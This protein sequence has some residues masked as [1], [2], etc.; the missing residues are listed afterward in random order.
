ME[1]KEGVDGHIP[2]EGQINGERSFLESIK[3][4]IRSIVHRD[5]PKGLKAHQEGLE[6]RL[7]AMDR[8]GEEGSTDN[9]VD[10]L[11]R[12][13]DFKKDSSKE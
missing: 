4:R 5:A 7:K 11:E 12:I 10:D 1:G 13:S 3:S 2:V 6:A 9:L 8:L